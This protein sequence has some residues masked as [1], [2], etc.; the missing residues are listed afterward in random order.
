MVYEKPVKGHYV[1]FI[2]VKKLQHPS[3]K[4]L[5]SGELIY[6]AKGVFKGARATE[7]V[8]WVT[9]HELENPGSGDTRS[10]IYRTPVH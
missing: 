8:V 10:A 5:S 7:S 9:E 6:T 3:L 1:W 4:K 2:P